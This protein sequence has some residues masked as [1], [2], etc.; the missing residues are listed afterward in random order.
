M[1][2]SERR[3]AW[4]YR[5]RWGNGAALTAGTELELL[6]DCYVSAVSGDIPAWPLPFP[7]RSQQSLVD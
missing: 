1:P 4:T 7:E 2:S 5:K 6:V 3:W